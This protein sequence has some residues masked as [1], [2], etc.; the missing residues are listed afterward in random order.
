LVITDSGGIQEETTALGV[1]CLTMRD[2]T[3]RPITVEQGTNVVV[4]RDRT[5]IVRHMNEILAG[6]GKRGRV[7][8]LWDGRASERIAAHLVPWLADR[9]ETAYA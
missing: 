7:P 3:E 5:L 2:N 1:P 8:E 4:G 6:G 9:V